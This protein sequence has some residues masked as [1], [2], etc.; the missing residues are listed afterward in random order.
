M[1]GN[2]Y[3]AFAKVPPE[4]KRQLNKAGRILSTP[5]HFGISA[6]E[7]QARKAISELAEKRLQEHTS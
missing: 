2:G 6:M 5:N 4:S 3:M 7:R 1:Q